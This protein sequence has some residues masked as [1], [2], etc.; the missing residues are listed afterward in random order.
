M[1]YWISSLSLQVYVHIFCQPISRNADGMKEVTAKKKLSQ[2]FYVLPPLY[3]K[4]QRLTGT[5]IMILHFMFTFFQM[6]FKMENFDLCGQKKITM[7]LTKGKD[8]KF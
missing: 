8:V 1:A 2:S 3:E 4:L 7:I 5:N 6:A